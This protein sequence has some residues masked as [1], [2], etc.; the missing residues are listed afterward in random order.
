MISK[1]ILPRYFVIIAMI[2]LLS[3]F[4]IINFGLTES[5]AE[6]RYSIMTENDKEEDAKIRAV[7][8][9]FKA[10]LKAKD[11]K[12]ALEYISEE[13]K[14]TY[15]YNFDLLKDHLDELSS[16]YQGDLEMDSFYDDIIANYNMSFEYKGE[17]FY[18]IVRFE[19][20]QNGEWKIRVF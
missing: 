5:N 2:I 11:I 15:E 18:S 12:K 14:E 20:D 3:S 13:A 16:I 19:K 10:A 4:Q 9:K 1:K 8:A 7:W 6:I 17:K